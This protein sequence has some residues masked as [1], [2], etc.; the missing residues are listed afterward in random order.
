[1]LTVFLI[2][3]GVV[4]YLN[5]GYFLGLWFFR[6]WKAAWDFHDFDTPAFVFAFPCSWLYGG[7]LKSDVLPNDFKTEKSYAR[8][9][10][11]VWPV[12]LAWSIA[13]LAI[14]ALFKAACLIL[15]LAVGLATLPMRRL[16][17]TN[18]D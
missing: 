15:S 5:I 4:V 1:M 14:F 18:G 10:A 17:G 11:F 9:I 16:F 2:A 8:F 3:V 12:K 7:S 13:I 6:V